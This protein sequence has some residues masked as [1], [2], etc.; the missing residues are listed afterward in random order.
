MQRPRREPVQCRPCDL[1][2]C[3]RWLAS[4]ALIAVGACSSAG[5]PS[6]SD[7]GGQV[8]LGVET[9]DDT[10]VEVSERPYQDVPSCAEPDGGVLPAAPASCSAPIR[11]CATGGTDS[12]LFTHL[13]ASLLDV[14]AACNVACGEFSLAFVGVCATGV[15]DIG[16]SIGSPRM[17]CL[18]SKLVGTRWD[19]APPDTWT[20]VYVDSCTLP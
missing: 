19:C 3:L 10:W 12:C 11:S 4:A 20:R 18:R 13:R 2:G 5:A 16:T 15:E 6:G 7:G 8:D 14:F 1:R 9:H 17:E